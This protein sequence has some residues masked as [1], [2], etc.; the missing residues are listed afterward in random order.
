MWVSRTW[1]I[2]YISISFVCV[3]FDECAALQYIDF[4]SH[5]HA[6]GHITHCLFRHTNRH[7]CPFLLLCVFIIISRSIDVLFVVLH[8]LLLR[9]DPFHPP[10]INNQLSTVLYAFDV[11]AVPISLSHPNRTLSLS[12]SLYLSLYGCFPPTQL[13]TY[14]FP[15]GRERNCIGQY[16]NNIKYSP[17]LD[18]TCIASKLLSKR[19]P[20]YFRALRVFNGVWCFSTETNCISRDSR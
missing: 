8:P 6:H 5:T 15:S 19:N 12:L 11:C 14:N 16:W 10:R 4:T 1:I 7:A 13:T 3:A 2:Y 17:Y 9:S 18:L 20:R